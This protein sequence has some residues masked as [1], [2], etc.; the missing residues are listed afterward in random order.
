MRGRTAAVLLVLALWT[1]APAAPDPTRPGRLAVGVTTA[2]A[3]D[4]SRGDRTFPVEIWYPARRSGRDTGPVWSAVIDISAA[5][6]AMASLTGLLLLFYIKRRR[7]RGL[8][9]AM[10]GAALLTAAYLLGVL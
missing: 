10:V 2:D 9:T 8:L 7:A 4:G 5:L 1:S 3:V 6:T